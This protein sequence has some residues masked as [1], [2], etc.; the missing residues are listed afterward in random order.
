MALQWVGG[1]SG[2]GS[3]AN[4]SVPLTSL[5]GGIGSSPQEGDIVIVVSGFAQTSDDNPGPITS[6]YTEVADLYIS[7]TADTN[8]SVSYKI[9][10]ATPD[11]SVEVGGSGSGTYGS[12]TVV[13]VW[14]GVDQSNPMDVPV[15]TATG[16]NG[17]NIDSPSI[18]PV[19]DGAVVLTCGLSAHAS[20][21]STK[22]VPSGYSNGVQAVSAATRNSLA[23]I[24]SKL[25]ASG[26]EDPGAWT[27]GT[28]QAFDS[29]AAV[30]LALRPATTGATE[31][32]AEVSQT[33]EDSTIASTAT[34]EIAA[35]VSQ[36]LDDATVSSVADVAG[37]ITADINQTLED[38]TL[39]S[40]ATVDIRATVSQTLE[41]ALLSSTGTVDVK[42]TVNQTLEDAVL[43]STIVATTV[44]VEIVAD[45]SISLEDAILSSAATVEVSAELSQTLEDAVVSS[46]LAY[47]SAISAQL[48]ETLEDATVSSTSTVDISAL[49]STILEDAQLT[50]DS[51]VWVSA[52]MNVDTDDAVV[53]SI[54][55]N[56][57]PQPATAFLGFFL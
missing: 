18:T 16:S 30:T 48:D 23:V 45:A 39:S 13:H 36:T 31:T 55:I 7:D 54:M 17:A 24:A 37:G 32:H 47:E 40:T 46:T 4:Y 14:R 9:V 44:D 53:S 12:A 41:D 1:A 35:S 27:G 3:G 10:G 57:T 56:D 29:W 5:S 2:I 50:S 51:S 19:T 38:A 25:W 15:I 22:T 28:S 33:L 21:G 34:V 52:S 8:A 43:S 20:G 11:T 42:A 49:I 6:G 26:S